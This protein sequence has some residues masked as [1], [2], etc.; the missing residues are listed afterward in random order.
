VK[1]VLCGMEDSRAGRARPLAEW[2]AEFRAK[3]NIPANL[4]P[5]SEEELN[6]FP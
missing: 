6:A 4:E 2:D 5:L 3:Y 1:A